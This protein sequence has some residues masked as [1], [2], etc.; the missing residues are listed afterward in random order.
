MLQ[1]VELLG[2]TEKL[3]EDQYYLSWVSC[4]FLN[5]SWIWVLIWQRNRL[6]I[7]RKGMGFFVGFS[8]VSSGL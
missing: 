7:R 3:E 6:F 8:A 1:V 4:T 2:E 5:Q